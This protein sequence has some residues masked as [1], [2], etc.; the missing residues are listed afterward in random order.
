M[1]NKSSFYL[2]IPFSYNSEQ[3]PVLKSVRKSVPNQCQL[4]SN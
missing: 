4:S 2:L 3:V 1:E